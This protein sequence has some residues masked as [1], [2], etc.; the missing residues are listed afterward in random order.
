MNDETATTG[1]TPG[2]DFDLD[3]FLRENN[4]L[5]EDNE[6]KPA[7][8]VQSAKKSKDK[9]STKTGQPKRRS[10]AVADDGAYSLLSA[11]KSVDTDWGLGLSDTGPDGSA[12][13]GISGNAGGGAGR[14]TNSS[15]SDGA[16]GGI[17]GGSQSEGFDPN[18]TMSYAAVGADLPEIPLVEERVQKPTVKKKRRQTAAAMEV[19]AVRDPFE[20]SSNNIENNIPTSHAIAADTAAPAQA[21]SAIQDQAAPSAQTQ[22]QA[23][24]AADADTVAAA[25]GHPATTGRATTELTQ[26]FRAKNSAATRKPRAVAPG[27]TAARRARVGGKTR[28]SAKRRSDLATLA[29]PEDFHAAKLTDNSYRIRG[30]GSMHIRRGPLIVVLIAVVIIAGIGLLAYGG[31]YAFDAIQH[32]GEKEIAVFLTEEE[33]RPAIDSEMPKII[34]YLWADPNDTLNGFVERGWNVRMNERATMTS[35]GTGMEIIH[36]A[37]GVSEDVLQGYYESEFNAYDFDELQ[38]SFNGCWV[39]NLLPGGDGQFGQLK[40]ANFASKSLTDE[41]AYL[42]EKQGLIGENVV[43]D[44]EGKD[45]FGNNYVQGYVTVGE[46]IYYWKLIGIAF[47]EY[48]RGQDRRDLPDTSVFVKCT[49]ATYDFYGVTI[50]DQ[51]DSGTAGDNGADTDSGAG[52]GSAGSTDTDSGNE[53]TANENATSEQ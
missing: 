29:N 4:F 24:P 49:V 8:G 6:D 13:A 18:A 20:P 15:T 41:L 31:K 36:L 37:P 52:N 21:A 17:S 50:N 32:A 1:G 16:G 35:G 42:R 28:G 25:S 27:V 3:A 43:V 5:V 7:S 46:T 39:L 11:G 45:D 48:Y 44:N 38:E 2:S 10:T 40:Y 26:N 51:D 33:T 9:G 23:V 34:D 53:G 19:A 47:S 12:S 22:A 14:T 30:G